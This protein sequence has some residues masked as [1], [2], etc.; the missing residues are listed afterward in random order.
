M[1]SD[2]ICP[3]RNSVFKV[4][5]HNQRE[6]AECEH[7]EHYSFGGNRFTLNCENGKTIIFNLDKYDYV[8]I[9]PVDNK[10]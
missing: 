9:N 8:E 4:K 5:L 3:G 1:N 6:T 2:N 10:D 7:V